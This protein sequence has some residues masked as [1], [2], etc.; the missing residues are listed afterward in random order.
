MTHTGRGRNPES[1]S[2]GFHCQ[3]KLTITDTSALA[4]YRFYTTRTVSL[5]CA[6]KDGVPPVPSRCVRALVRRCVSFSGNRGGAFLY[7][8]EL[9]V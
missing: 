3:A 8:L 1:N 7:F 6:A 2:C 4:K 5:A 9:F